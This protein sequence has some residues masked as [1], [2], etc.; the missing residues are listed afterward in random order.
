MI[1]R[2]VNDVRK[3]K[4]S[5]SSQSTK[6]TNSRL[7][8]FLVIKWSTVYT[9]EEEMSAKEID[10]ATEF[11]YSILEKYGKHPQILEQEPLI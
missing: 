9:A 11:I 1:W 7:F 3:F 5:N 2:T 8:T 10:D 6:C 4:S